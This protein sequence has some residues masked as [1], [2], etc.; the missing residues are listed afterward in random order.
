MALPRFPRDA[1]EK[2]PWCP[3][4]GCREGVFLRLNQHVIGSSW[5]FSSN[6][7]AG[8]ARGGGGALQGADL[9]PP[10]DSMPSGPARRPLGGAGPGHV[11]GGSRVLGRLL[12][13]DVAAR[14]G[15]S[16]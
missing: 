13:A 9:T 5:G 8:V 16:P 6:R 7:A 15:K 10:R 11:G 2:L 12:A 3:L 4:R 14:D 1:L